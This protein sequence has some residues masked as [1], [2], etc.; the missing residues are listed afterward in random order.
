MSYVITS[1]KGDK[2]D[3]DLINYCENYNYYTNKLM[4]QC[5][6]TPVLNNFGDMVLNVAPILKYIG[7]G[8]AVFA[9]LMLTNFISTSIVYK[10]RE[11][12]V[13]R[14]IGARAKDVFAIFFSESMII[15]LINFIL[16]TIASGI[17]CTVI[18]NLFITDLI[19]FSYLVAV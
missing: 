6:G 19:C 1:L 18:N 14:A 16:S 13:L 9:G 10:K 17:I 11:I 8:L 5:Q 4:I 3:T 2:N 12:G 7:I 15:C